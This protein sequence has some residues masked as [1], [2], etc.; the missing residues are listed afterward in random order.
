MK[1]LSSS[2]QQQTAMLQ[3]IANKLDISLEGVTASHFQDGPGLV[4]PAPGGGDLQAADG[5]GLDRARRRSIHN[6]GWRGERPRSTV[7]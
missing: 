6:L 1:L 2:V 7:I 5:G 4:P 3:Q